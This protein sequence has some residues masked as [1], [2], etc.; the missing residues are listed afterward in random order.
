MKVILEED[1]RREDHEVVIRCRDKTDPEIQ[2]TVKALE[3]LGRK[4][5]ATLPGS[6]ELL[7]LDP[8]QVLYTES[9]DGR[10]YACTREAVHPVHGS[11]RQMESDFGFFRCSKAMAVNLMEI[12]RLR[13]EAGGRI[14]VELSNGEKVL[15]SRRYAAL[16]RA[17]L[18][19]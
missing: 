5:L 13:S 11:L 10:V 16:L 3:S 9:V 17:R 12:R 1:P 7:V 8:S 4:L 2:R 15:V 18:Q 14:L 6:R 19:M